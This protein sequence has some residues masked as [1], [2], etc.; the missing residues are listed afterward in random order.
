MKDPKAIRKAIMTAKSIAH[1]VD[2]HFGRV[3]LPELGDFGADKPFH[4]H[5]PM[6]H[7]AYGVPMPEHFASGGY[8]DGGDVVGGHHVLEHMNST[9]HESGLNKPLQEHI[10]GR[11]WRLQKIEPHHIPDMEHDVY[12]DDPFGRVIDFDDDQIRHYKHKLALGHSIPPIIKSGDAILD[13]NHRAQAAKELGMPIHAYVPADEPEH[14]AAGGYAEGGSPKIDYFQPDNDMGMYSHAANVAS[15]LPQERGSPEQFAGMLRNQGVKPEEMKWSEYDSAFGDRPQVTRDE[16]AK[17]FYVNMPN[18]EEKWHQ[19]SESAQSRRRVKSSHSYER[20]RLR[21]QFGDRHDDE[22]MAAFRAMRQRHEQELKSMPHDDPYHEEYTIPGGKN[23]REILLKHGDEDKF[24]G[25]QGHFGKEPGI[26]A[27]LRMKDREDTEGNKVLH[28][29]ELQSDWGQKARKHGYTDPER[30][31]QATAKARAA[32]EAF[33]EANAGDDTDAYLST[34]EARI[35]AMQ[36]LESAKQAV[37]PAPYIGKTDDWVDL[38]L[39]R[40]LLEAAKGG[41]DKL[42]WSPG[43]VQ[44]DRYDLSKH[45]GEIRHEKNDDGTYNLDVSNPSGLRIFDKDDLSADELADHVGKELAEKIVAGHGEKDEGPSYRDWRTLSGLDLKVGGEGMRHFYDNLLPK[46]L[47]R[48]AKMHDP[49]AKLSHTVIEHPIEHG[50]D[51]RL[52]KDD[53]TSTNLPALAITP[54]MRESILKKGFPA[55][56]EGG[57]VEGYDRGGSMPDMDPELFRQKLKRIHSPLSENPEAVQHALRIAQSYRH[58]LGAETGTGSFYNIKQSMPASKV[59]ATIGDIPG[60]KLQSPKKKSWEDFYHRGKGGVFINMGGDLSN[61]GRMTHINDKELAWP[62]DL[63]AG[64][65]YMLEPNPGKVWANAAAH[66]SSFENKIREAEEAGKEAFGV[67]APMGP[68]AVNSSHNM[69]DALMAQIPGAGISKK[70]MREFDK[71]LKSGSHLDANIRGNPKKLEAH[72]DALKAWPGLEN[73][74]ESSAYARPEAGNLSGVH[75]SMIVNFMDKSNWRDKG[76][77]EVGITRAAITD[78]E[79]KGIGG[80]KIGHRV[81]KLSS[82]P[83]EPSKTLFKHSTY[84]VDTSGEYIMDV[85]AI[86]RHYAAPDVMDRLIGKPTKAGQIV[87]PYS[88]DALGRAT[89]RKLLEE[90]KQVQPVN[91]RMLDSAM[92]GMENQEKYGFKKGGAVR[93]ALMIAKGGK[94]K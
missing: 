29:D 8:A 38:G 39:K 56:A 54:R 6:I 72:L 76:F 83:I 49:D 16:I 19:G 89:A 81:V 66:A 79:L 2:P 35:Q 23:Y 87:H 36:E 80:N 45:V 25:V 51:E 94:K 69:F 41:H 15:Q 31:R 50:D 92:M 17:H 24:P 7:A 63:H 21:E 65:K 10:L 59:R 88:E 86:Q 30:V 12:F 78:P 53:Y 20:D 71:A 70:D 18:I 1:I 75:R 44:A 3:P 13:G 34:R 33:A 73:A 55:Y 85:P 68:T 52:G 62:V 47:M 84:P 27:S 42:A 28:L 11:K 93:R 90:Q 4:E 32:N 9:H 46:R 61:F 60:I 40:A 91:Q 77:P 14:F 64:T 58:P 57:E 43:D 74:K 67:F 37:N 26:L 48:L 5:S 82:K 22:A